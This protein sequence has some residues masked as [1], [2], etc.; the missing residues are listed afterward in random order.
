MGG[1]SGL[2]LEPHPATEAQRVW[3]RD[4]PGSVAK[5]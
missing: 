5:R 1:L 4:A 2:G 3:R